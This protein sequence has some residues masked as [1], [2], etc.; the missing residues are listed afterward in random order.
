M[1]TVIDATQTETAIDQQQHSC[2]TL[3]CQ[4]HQTILKLLSSAATASTR[5][6]VRELNCP[7]TYRF[8]ELYD[9]S[10]NKLHS[11][12]RTRPQ[13]VHYVT[14]NILYRGVLYSLKVMLFHGTRKGQFHSHTEN[15][16]VSPTSGSTAVQMS[17]TAVLLGGA[18]CSLCSA[19][20]Y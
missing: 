13:L 10:V 8:W 1:H 12:E 2:E 3:I 20:V 4:P 19:V 17:G 7:T 18:L 11:C 6:R 16:P 9:I 15:K 5:W 14:K